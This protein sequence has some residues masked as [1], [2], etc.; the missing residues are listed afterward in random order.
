[1]INGHGLLSHGTLKSAVSQDKLMSCAEFLHAD[2]NSENQKNTSLIFKLLWSK[3]GM[4][5]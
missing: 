2:I 4:V 5:F 1:M 3:M